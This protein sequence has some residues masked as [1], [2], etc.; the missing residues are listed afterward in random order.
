MATI[1][2]NHGLGGIKDKYWAAQEI[3]NAHRIGPRK[4]K[5]P[6]IVRFYSRPARNAIL[7]DAKN[8]RPGRYQIYEDLTDGD[9]ALK[10]RARTQMK[11]A[12]DAGK[13]TR[14]YKGK[15]YIDSQE[16][17]IP[18][19]K[20][21]VEYNDM[22]CFWGNQS[23]FSNHYPVE[24]EINGTK[25][26]TPEHYI[27]H[28]KANEFDDVETARKILESDDPKVAKKLGREIDGFDMQ[29]W[30]DVSTSIVETAARAKFTQHQWLQDMLIQTGNKMMVEASP[31]DK[32]WG[33]GLCADNPKIKDKS[34]WKG[35][36]KFGSILM[37]V[38]DSLVQIDTVSHL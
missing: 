21:S 5:R 3:E 19:R 29:T 20:M 28:Q 32:F 31:V 26:K 6:I 24:V 30:K 37:E 17:K 35:R 8:M 18:Q 38:R 25:Y 15:L 1:I 27:M 10:A 7:R 14:F 23:P 22:V 16:T 9:Y 33:V 12:H 36:N 2:A 4:P 11:Q 34:N 13:K